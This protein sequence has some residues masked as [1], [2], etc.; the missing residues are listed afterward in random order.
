MTPLAHLDTGKMPAV[1]SQTRFSCF[2][3]WR[4]ELSAL[5]YA[6]VRPSAGALKDLTSNLFVTR[7]FHVS[8][9]NTFSST[10]TKYQA[11][12]TFNQNHST[13]TDRQGLLNRDCVC[14]ADCAVQFQRTATQLS[15]HGEMIWYMRPISHTIWCWYCNTARRSPTE[16]SW[17]AQDLQGNVKSIQHRWS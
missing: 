3:I 6:H 7:N 16:M 2:D 12:R 9:F 13:R 15:L 14:I 8:S 11:T 1:H 10:D 17:F 5:A 4:I